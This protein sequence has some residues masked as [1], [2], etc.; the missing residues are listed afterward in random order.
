MRR[1]EFIA[2]LGGAAAWPLAVRAQPAGKVWRIGVLGGSPHPVLAENYSGFLRGMRELGYVEGKDFITELRAAENSYERL[3]VLAAELVRVGAD[4]LLTATPAAMKA[5]QDATRTIPII[6]VAIT[7]PVG[8]GY[9]A[10]LAHPGGNITGLA[11][12][13]DEM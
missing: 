2:G 13:Y 3:P 12:S 9:I 7:D 11:S 4:V 1:R 6:M 10:S 5:L 8:N